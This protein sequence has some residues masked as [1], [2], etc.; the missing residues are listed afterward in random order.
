MFLSLFRRLTVLLR[1]FG[2]PVA[3]MGSVLG[4][5]RVRAVAISSVLA[6]LPKGMV[7]LATVLLVSE[8][9]G[10]YLIAGGVAGVVAVSDA[11][12]TPLQGRLVD[13]LGLYWVVLSAAAVQVV[14]VGWLLVDTGDP[15]RRFAAAGLVGLGNPPISAGMKAIWPQLVGETALPTAYRIE[16]LAQQLIFLTGPLAVTLAVSIGSPVLAL[17]LSA[18]LVAVGS[19]WFVLAIPVRFAVRARRRQAGALR[20][21]AVRTLIGA[22][23]L[24]GIVFGGVPVGLAAFAAASRIPTLA[25]ALQSALTV[26]GVL[27]T[28][29]PVQ[30]V[31]KRRYVRSLTGF[32]L[33]LVAV[34]TT[35]VASSAVPMVF[36]LVVAGFFL[37]PVAAASYVLMQ[38]ATDLGNRTEAFAW[39]SAGLAV[40]SAL[41]SALSGLLVD[42]GTAVAALALLPTAM[43]SAALWTHTQL[44]DHQAC[45]GA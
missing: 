9:T 17:A 38:R 42:H 28:F 22:T 32:A 6:R 15:V 24:Q 45:C 11:A 26:G 7:P 1:R 30:A 40:G 20:S 14:G 33:G 5:P 12:T 18:G 16:S 2:V 35:A 4:V 23:A 44:P 36:F 19:V 27:G 29:A 43:A 10:S 41:G 3:A 13:R 37:T 31:D 8:R 39:M 25:G 34:A 21:R